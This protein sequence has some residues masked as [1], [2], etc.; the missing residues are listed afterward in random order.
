LRK[1]LLAL[2]LT[3]AL[4]VLAQA[5]NEAQPSDAPTTHANSAA[6]AEG[7]ATT[8]S[9]L[10]RLSILDGK[11][12][13]L[14]EK[15]SEMDGVIDILRKLKFSGYVQGRYT[16]V[17]NA[18]TNTFSVRRARLK[19]SYANDW[20]QYVLQIDAVPTGLGGSG[21]TLKDAEA[22][23][24][25][26]WTGY[27]LDFTV[28]QMKWP[29][30]YEV[31]QS[32][33]DREFPERTRVIRSFFPSERDRGARLSGK[34]NIFRFAVGVFDGTGT[35]LKVATGADQDK[36]KDVVGRIGIDTKMF[37]VGA[38]GW[39]GS[40]WDPLTSK[41]YDRNRLGFDAQ[42]YLDLLP[43]GATA[44]KA[45]FVAGRTWVNNGVEQFGIPAIGWYALLVQNLGL[46]D[47]VAVRYDYFD[48]LA[49]TEDNVSQ[50]DPTKPGP[51]NGIGQLGFTYLHH[52][53]GGLKASITYEIPMTGTAN[54]ATDP[55]DNILTLQLQAKF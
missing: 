40:T 49:G 48:P 15:G 6:S 37:S 23:L 34:I 31:T 45:E 55:Q 38:S 35:A 44:I 2:T 25:E 9:V 24:I 5:S 53:P 51:N 46:N 8:P 36:N 14:E 13:S 20:S 18:T 26:P 16:N 39:V 19:V 42:A 17:D 27:K 43:I 28:G 21:V 4:P 54:A 22:H 29:F 50:N 47:A 1:L 52:F 3:S 10:D 30:G 32:S 7:D 12:A 33:G 41:T 11:L